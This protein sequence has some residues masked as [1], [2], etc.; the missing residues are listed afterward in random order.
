MTLAIR[1]LSCAVVLAACD[2]QVVSVP[3]T[4][5]VVPPDEPDLDVD[6]GV[7]AGPDPDSDPDPDPVDA[8]PDPEPD[9]EPVDAGPDPDPDPDPVD[10]APF[11]DFAFSSTGIRHIVSGGVDLLGG[12]GSYYIIGSCSGADDPGQNVVSIGASGGTLFAPGTC[13]GPP[14]AITITRTSNNAVHA[15]VR[16][17]PTPV[18]YRGFSVPLDA[19]KSFFTSFNTTA[20]GF[21]VGCGDGYDARDGG[22]G[23]FADIPTPCFIPAAGPVGTARFAPVPSMGEITG[24]FGTIRR[25]VTSGD[26]REL[27]FYNHPNTNNIEVSFTTPGNLPAGSTLTLE[28]DIVVVAAAVP[29]TRSDVL[30]PLVYR[31]VLGREP[32]ASGAASFGPS[33]DASG[34]AGMTQSATAML[35]SAE[36]AN[37]R[38]TLS[39]AQVI[40][41]FYRGLLG[42]PADPAG[43]ANFTPVVDQGAYLDLW[44]GLL[45]SPEF[46]TAYPL[47]FP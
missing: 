29:F 47:A 46:T 7:D 26:G 34:S 11:V 22:G 36:F 3:R 30:L 25:T 4:P 45:A 38:A 33:I 5:V 24:P 28:E 8:G 40:D 44:N 6:D 9:P 13:P 27:Y 39:T 23:N 42:R 12:N 16:I 1:F 32:D 19:K 2:R 31:A 17:G 37:L 15:S 41:Q 18:E 14:F 21:G 20:P 35:Q 10:N 43:I